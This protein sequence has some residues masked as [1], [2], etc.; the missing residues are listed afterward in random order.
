MIRSRTILWL[1]VATLILMIT[2]NIQNKLLISPSAPSGIISLE[3]SN[4]APQVKE[5]AREWAGEK[6]IA[7]YINMALDYF[8]LLFYGTFLYL[9]CRYFA[10]RHIS[11]RKTGIYASVA[12]LTAAGLDAI[13]NGLMLIHIN[14][15]PSD[16]LAV[17]TSAIATTKFILAAF[18]VLFLLYAAISS[19]FPGR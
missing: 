11:F 9:A 6:M 1:L 19:L 12:G 17:M 5:I 8:Y 2:I 10:L 3:L 4:T 14:F 7:F 16:F 15:S 18:A 13:E